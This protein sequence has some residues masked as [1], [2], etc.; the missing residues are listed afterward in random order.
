M[1]LGQ[2]VHRFHLKSADLEAIHWPQT[3]SRRY[4]GRFFTVRYGV[5]NVIVVG[6][7]LRHEVLNELDVAVARS[8]HARALPA[9][10][11]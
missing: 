6:R 2:Y 3:E 10:L 8:L 4:R 5:T 7:V 9:L 11:L 1:A